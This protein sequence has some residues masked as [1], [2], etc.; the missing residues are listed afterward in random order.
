M[1]NLL[2][3]FHYVHSTRLTDLLKVQKELTIEEETQ[4]INTI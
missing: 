1:T 2:V 4:A 3:I